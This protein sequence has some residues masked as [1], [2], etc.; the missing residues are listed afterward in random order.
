MI[1]HDFI[2]WPKVIAFVL[3]LLEIYGVDGLRGAILALRAT[4]R[5]FNL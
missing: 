3:W 2:V 5:I 1:C 4:C